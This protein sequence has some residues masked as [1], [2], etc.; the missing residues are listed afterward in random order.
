MDGGGGWRHYAHY[1]PP[2]PPF[3]LPPPVRYVP[4][5]FH[6]QRACCVLLLALLT[7]VGPLLAWSSVCVILCALAYVV[8]PDLSDGGPPGGRWCSVVALPP[9]T[10]LEYRLLA[11]PGAAA[12]A[13]APHPPMVAGYQLHNAPSMWPI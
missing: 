10:Q 5:D 7:A 11:W 3:A 13:S 4:Y 8:L 12:C 9:H 6:R 2:L 1:A